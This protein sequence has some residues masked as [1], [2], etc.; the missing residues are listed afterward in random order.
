LT[1]S[2]QDYRAKESKGDYDGNTAR[3]IQNLIDAV[4]TAK[5]DLGAIEYRQKELWAFEAEDD[6]DEEE[7]IEQTELSTRADRI[8]CVAQLC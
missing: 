6:L 3:R 4:E 1:K 2:I 8:R 7:K 5:R